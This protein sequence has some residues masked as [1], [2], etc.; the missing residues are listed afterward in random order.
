MEIKKHIDA[1]LQQPGALSVFGLILYTGEHAHLAMVLRDPDYWK[2]FDIISGNRFVILSARPGKPKRGTLSLMKETWDDPEANRALLST[3]HVNSTEHLPKFVV[4][5]Q[6]PDD[7]ILQYSIPLTDESKEAAH[8]QL[9]EV[10]ATV[11]SAAAKIANEYA[12]DTE[13]IFLAFETAIKGLKQRQAIKNSLKYIPFV[14]KILK[15]LTGS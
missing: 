3:F 4:F 12:A 7:S 9:K 8:K 2:Q 6:M 14:E 11:S 5:A 15:L 1:A 10:I 13:G